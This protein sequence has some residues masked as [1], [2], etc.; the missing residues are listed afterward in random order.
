MSKGGEKRSERD[1]PRKR[2]LMR[3]N[4][5]LVTREEMDGEVGE[6]SDEDFFFKTLF[7]L[8]RQREVEN[9]QREASSI[10]GLWDHDLSQ[11]QT[12]KH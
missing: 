8:E 3:V 1:K 2:L 11:R 7:I 12:L 5:L 10:P 4:K 9:R 6:I